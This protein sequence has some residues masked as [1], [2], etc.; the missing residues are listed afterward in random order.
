[1][2]AHHTRSGIKYS[3]KYSNSPPT[4]STETSDNIMP[5]SQPSL[6]EL[7]EFHS[8]SVYDFSTILAAKNTI[9]TWLYNRSESKK[10]VP[11]SILKELVD[12]S[13]KLEVRSLA[14]SSIK[15]Q[16]T[17]ATRDISDV[18]VASL[19]QQLVSVPQF[20]SLNRGNF[21]GRSRGFRGRNTYNNSNSS[22]NN[23]P[24]FPAL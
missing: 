14:Y 21:R 15:F 13:S 20:R 23:T 8:A 22:S 7:P 2:S 1:M 6:E 11:F 10:I 24:A 4:S 12:I 17:V 3:D 5:G 9:A 19:N 16:L 18:Q